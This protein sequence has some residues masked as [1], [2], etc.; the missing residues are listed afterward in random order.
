MPVCVPLGSNGSIWGAREGEKRETDKTIGL[1]EMEGMVFANVFCLKI[2]FHKSIFKTFCMCN[3]GEREIC[4]CRMANS[5]LTGMRVPPEEEKREKKKHQIFVRLSRYVQTTSKGEKEG[6]PHDTSR[7]YL[8]QIV[9]CIPPI[10]SCG[11]REEARHDICLPSRVERGGKEEKGRERQRR[12]RRMER[13]ERR[14]R[15]APLSSPPFLFQVGGGG[16]GGGGGVGGGRK[17]NA[18]KEERGGMGRGWAGT[19]REEEEE[20]EE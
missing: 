17:G 20:E 18:P 1:G 11:G 4:H 14:R 15:R 3:A 7:K 6:T 2:H 8:T 19:K 10:S 9:L 13:E 16:R 12:R 5:H